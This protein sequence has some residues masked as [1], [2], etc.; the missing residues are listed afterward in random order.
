MYKEDVR[1]VGGV[2]FKNGVTLPPR[3]ATRVGQEAVNRSGRS[4]YIDPHFLD[5]CEV[6][7]VGQDTDCSPALDT[8]AKRT[9][10]TAPRRD[11]K[12]PR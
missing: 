11:R 12:R 3:A 2:G 8:I 4:F 7:Q 6:G 1:G 10:S 5:L 9:V